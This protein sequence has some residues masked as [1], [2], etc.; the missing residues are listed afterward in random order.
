VVSSTAATWSSRH[1]VVRAADEDLT[2]FHRLEGGVGV[3]V[4]AADSVDVDEGV[5]VTEKRQAVVLAAVRMHLDKG[6][7]VW[8]RN[9]SVAR[10]HDSRSLWRIVGSIAST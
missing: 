8:R 10:H 5:T 2:E 6:E 7:P 4:H 3:D 9:S 1:H